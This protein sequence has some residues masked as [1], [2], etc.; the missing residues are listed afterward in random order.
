MASMCQNLSS[1]GPKHV[2][3]KLKSNSRI[4]FNFLNFIEIFYQLMLLDIIKSSMH[5]IYEWQFLRTKF[6]ALSRAIETLALGL[7]VSA[8]QIFKIKKNQKN[9]R[10]NLKKKKFFDNNFV[11]FKR[12]IKQ[13]IKQFSPRAKVSIA[14]ERAGGPC[15]SKKQKYCN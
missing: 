14:R 4:F 1:E 3:P 11:K 15:F 12:K 7:L 2:L 5:K 8:A 13:T 9:L 6:Y 10:I